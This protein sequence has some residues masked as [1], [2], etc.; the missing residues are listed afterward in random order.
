V[1]LDKLKVLASDVVE[2]LLHLGEG[3]FVIVHELV[4]VLIFALLD[5]VDFNF[6][7]QVELSLQ[8][9]ELQFIILN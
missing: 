8:A 5:F 9:L 4:D 1:L 2:V 6:H 7:S 3:F